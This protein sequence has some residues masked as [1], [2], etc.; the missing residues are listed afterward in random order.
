[1][2]ALEPNSLI[3]VSGVTGYLGSHTGLAA[4][5]LGHR[6]RGSV[7]SFERAESLRQVFVK[8]GINEDRFEFVG[9]EE[10]GNEQV[11]EEAIQG[12]Y[13]HTLSLL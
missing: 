10:L 9:V 2:P 12:S 13:D 7:R 3:F 4:L 6:I 5:K 1:M 8:E 11:W